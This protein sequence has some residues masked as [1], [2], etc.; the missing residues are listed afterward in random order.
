MRT[1]IDISMCFSIQG[2]TKRTETRFNFLVVGG[3]SQA[4]TEWG[5]GEQ[6]QITGDQLRFWFSK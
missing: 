1:T 6:V 5:E 4:R 2:V 3:T